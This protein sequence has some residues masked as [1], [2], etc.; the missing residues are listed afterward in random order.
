M[1]YYD[2]NQ[3]PNSGYGGYNPQ[4]P[5]GGDPYSGG[6]YGNPQQGSGQYGGQYGA[7]QQG[8]GQYG[9]PQQ[10]SGQY[11]GQ[12]YGQP[13]YG[14]QPPYGD[15]QYAAY[16]QQNPYYQ[17]QGYQAGGPSTVSNPKV[18]AGFCYIA[19]VGLIFF[20]IE[21][22]N[23]F[24]RFHALQG[25]LYGVICGVVISIISN[26][27]GVI[28]ANSIGLALFGSCLTGLLGLAYLGGII[29]LGIS[30]YQGKKIKLPL[31]GDWVERTV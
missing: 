6:Q 27:I 1:S 22:Q 19:I 20:I 10:G 8:S 13:P 17:Q 5:A 30:A 15:P 25:L 16:Q 31:I 9:N 23:K 24:L 3:Q 12:Q 2:P 21:K 18:A 14:Q 29:F 4:H 11:G 26:I 7:P 28:A